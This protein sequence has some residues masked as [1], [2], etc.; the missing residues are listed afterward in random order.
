MGLPE[1]EKQP[2]LLDF[3]LRKIHPL[4]AN[5]GMCP[6]WIWGNGIDQLMAIQIAYGHISQ[7]P[8]ADIG[9][10]ARV[11]YMMQQLQQR[12]TQ[13]P[14][15][16]ILYHSA[17]GRMLPISEAL[18]VDA[19]R[20]NQAYVK[21]KNKLEIYTNCNKEKHWKLTLAGR[22]FDL[23]PF[24]WAAAAPGF[25]DYSAEFDGRRIDYADSPVYTYV[26]AGGKPFDFGPVET[27]GSLVIRKDH[28]SGLK[29]IPISGATHALLKRVAAARITAFNGDNR[30]LGPASFEVTESGTTIE[31]NPNARYYIVTAQVEKQLD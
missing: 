4:Q 24:G 15:E 14:V 5:V 1:P 25:L 21:Y 18:P 9:L 3:D 12:Y 28:P 11:Y 29:I 19:N 27:A 6:W 7:I 26:S 8:Q 13:V 10:A 20:E 22:E 23:P 30:D 31:F 2:L 17:D 16:R